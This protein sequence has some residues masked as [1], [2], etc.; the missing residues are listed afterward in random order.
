[1]YDAAIKRTTNCFS[2]AT[3][4]ATKFDGETR[5]VHHDRVARYATGFSWENRRR[6]RSRLPSARVSRESSRSF[7][8][9]GHASAEAFKFINTSFRACEHA[10]F[11]A[12]ASSWEARRLSSSFTIRICKFP[13]SARIA[14][15][16]S[17]QYRQY[18]WDD[19]CIMKSSIRTSRLAIRG[20]NT[21][22]EL[23]KIPYC[24]C[25]DARENFRLWGSFAC[26]IIPRAMFFLSARFAFI[27]APLVR[28]TR[29]GEEHKRCKYNIKLTSFKKIY[30]KMNY[31]RPSFLDEIKFSN[32]SIGINY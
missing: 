15:F 2:A 16:A 10:K 18:R 23:P 9:P 5:V 29:T 4:S 27:P 7:S 19:P 13:S 31:F 6:R 30:L 20:M 28:P 3:R 12:Y 1:M 8:V 22:G 14:L 26:T 25:G 11:L 24:A 17:V 21:T 32:Y